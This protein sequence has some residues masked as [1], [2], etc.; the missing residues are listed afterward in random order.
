MDDWGVS[1]LKIKGISIALDLFSAIKENVECIIVSHSILQNL[2]DRHYAFISGR[3]EKSDASF[4]DMPNISKWLIYDIG[5]TQ[6]Y[7]L[8]SKKSFDSRKFLINIALGEDANIKTEFPLFKLPRAKVKWTVG[9]NIFDKDFT[10]K[11][12]KIGFAD[13]KEFYN[14]IKNPGM[15]QERQMQNLI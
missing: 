13:L 8:L 9:K 3:G 4:K 2:L 10:S 1:R 6:F 15:C 14:F 5:D 12:E 7:L 11:F